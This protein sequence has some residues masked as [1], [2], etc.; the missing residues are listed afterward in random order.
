MIVDMVEA[1]S[2]GEITD[3]WLKAKSATTSL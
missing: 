1:T 3:G 2:D